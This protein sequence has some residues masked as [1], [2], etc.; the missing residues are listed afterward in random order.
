MDTTEAILYWKTSANDAFDT[1]DKLFESKKFDHSLFFVH[2]SIEKI[3][4]ALFIQIKQES[5]LFTHDLVR[6]AESCELII[7]EEQNFQ[8]V[9]I[10]TFNISARYDDYKLK[11]YKKATE[12][13]SAQWRKTGKTL[14]DFFASKLP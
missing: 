6:L 10:S 9:E 7:T 2:L 12:A 8:L 4:K 13:Y 11:F 14:F 3:L 5:P 1:S